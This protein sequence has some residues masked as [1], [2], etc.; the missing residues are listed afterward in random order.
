MMRSIDWSHFFGANGFNLLDSMSGLSQLIVFVGAVCGLVYFFFSKAHTGAFGG[1]AKFGIWILMIGFGASFG[2]TV[3]A[4]ISLFINR[5]Q[6]LDQR[7]IKSALATTAPWW[8]GLVL[9]LV[10]AVAV[11]YAAWELAAFLRHKKNSETHRAG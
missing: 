9:S 11:A 10:V 7:W 8:Y 5:V 1:M 6:F 3:M 4:R 2:F